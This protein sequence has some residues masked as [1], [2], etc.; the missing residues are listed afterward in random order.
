VSTTA[1]VTPLPGGA[2]CEAVAK[3]AEVQ[4]AFTSM[5]RGAAFRY[6]WYWLMGVGGA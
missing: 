5:P 4:A 1:T 3:L 2:S 6:H